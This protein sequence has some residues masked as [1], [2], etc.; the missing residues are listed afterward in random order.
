MMCDTCGLVQLRDLVPG[1]EMYEHMYGYRSGISATMRAHLREY[2]DEIMLL[3]AIEDGDAV[4]DIGSNDATFLK[5]YPSCLK[6]HG[7]DPTGSQFASEYTDLLLTP[8][9]F[10]KEA[11]A[12]LGLKYKVVSSISMFY[13]LPDPVQF[14][15]DVYD[16]LHEDGLWTFEQSYLKTMLER[17]S[18]D[19]ICHE[20]VEY[21]GVRQLK[22]ILDLAGFKIV[23]ISLN[24]CNGGSTR[25]FAAKKESRWTEDVR[26][27]QRLL[28]G[29]AHL[30]DPKTYGAFMDR[31]DREIAKLEAHL[32][33]GKKTY[34]YGAS[35]KGNCLLQYAGIGPD[36]VKYA[37][38]R[39][40]A[41]VG[42]KT[43]TGIEIISEETMR[44]SPPDYLLVLPWHF[45][46]EI[47]E[48]ESAFL[49][50]GGKLIFP[51]P[52]FEIVGDSP[53]L[54]VRYGCGGRLGDTLHQLSVV[55]EI[56]LKTGQKG[57]VYL[58][59]TLGDSFDRNI[60]ST[61]AD[62][63]GVVCAQPYIESFQLHQGEEFDIN[64]SKWRTHEHSYDK[65]WHQA[66]QGA[67]GIPWNTTPWISVVPNLQYKDTIFIS[68]GD[69]R[70]NWV[71]RYAELKDRIP[72]LV[73][74]A[75]SQEMYEMFVHRNGVEMPYLVCPT[76]SDLANV[77]MACKGF[78]GNLSMP[79][80]LA[81]AMW[82]PRLAIM[83][84]YDYDC[85]VAM[86]T[87][88]RYIINTE[89]LD[90]FGWQTPAHPHLK[91]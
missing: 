71:L 44:A 29:E 39:N 33:T 75:T 12:P 36:R 17:N 20:H 78:I 4:L 26:M 70:R 59:N 53:A 67:F 7:C 27:V 56:Y 58:S 42:C 72:N 69:N 76:F 65:S 50:A 61:F 73:F 10:T 8:T 46:A 5:M 79:L 35:T 55:N 34:V 19:T 86:L 47:V 80:A 84:S 62:I 31:C 77:L 23:R 1:S 63:K 85:R 82:K 51:L 45:K 37:V 90:A 68:C 52:T 18:F 48:R 2:H 83:Y 9:Y 16:V 15:H 30:A 49:K 11:V 41:K 13:D 21:Y 25:I 87:D 22:H 6:R 43:S 57:I 40:P 64:L 38:E 66:F 14:A 74:L 91:H 88:S 54:S 3:A 24:D 28:D 60:E 32:A 89:D 81:D